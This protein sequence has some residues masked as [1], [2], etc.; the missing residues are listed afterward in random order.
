MGR[1]QEIQQQILARLGAVPGLVLWRNN[2]GAMRDERGQLVRYGQPGSADVLG[3]AAPDGRFVALEIK[4]PGGKQSE[5][6]RAWQQMVE[7][8]GGIDWLV[9]SVDEARAGLV[10]CGIDC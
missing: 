1:E 10:R 5:L 4:A 2:T 6:Q 7:R 3:L 9:T 8:H